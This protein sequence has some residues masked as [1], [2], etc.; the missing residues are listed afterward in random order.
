MDQGVLLAGAYGKPTRGKKRARMRPRVGTIDLDQSTPVPGSGSE[1]Y[2]TQTVALSFFPTF[3]IEYRSCAEKRRLGR[4]GAREPHF[5]VV[6]QDDV[7]FGAK[8]VCGMKPWPGDGK[9]GG[10][11]IMT[12]L[13]SVNRDYCA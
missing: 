9:A 8:P 2:V 5:T 3:R 1:T 6:Y 4:W 7:G 11:M 10:A 12:C 13:F